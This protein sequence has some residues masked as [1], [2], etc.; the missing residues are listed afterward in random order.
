MP[1][2]ATTE[3]VW[4]IGS[5]L[6]WTEKFLATKGV[7]APRLDA[8]LLLAHAL[9]CRRPDLYTRYEET[10]SAEARAAFRA[11]IER[12]TAGCPVAYLIGQ[13]EFFLLSFDVSPAVL[14]PRPSTESLVLA[15]LERAK[16]VEA[17]RALDIGTGSGCIAISVA[18]RNKVARVLAV[19]ISEDALAVARRNAEKHGVSGRV[20][21]QRSDLFA[22]I[23][24]GARF[25]FILSNPPY[26]P[27]GDIAV[28]HKDIR[29]HEPRPALDGGP[30]GFAV[31]DRL[32]ADAPRFL[33]HGGWLMLEIGVDQEAMARKKLEAI[34]ALQ[35]ERTIKDGDGRPRV[36]AAQRR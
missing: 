29:D 33:N 5:L 30:D 3:Q 14:I 23:D 8:Q 21:F 4:T 11:L 16:S 2:A 9:K 32:I 28:L 35:I 13:K 1:P 24:P 31:F 22:G 12:R 26:I 7:E 27:T 6:Q 17:P 34:P 18:H 36:L 25:D 15:C 10:P 20:R 19:D